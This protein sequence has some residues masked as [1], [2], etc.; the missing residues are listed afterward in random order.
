MS[1][2]KY[3]TPKLNVSFLVFPSDRGPLARLRA[4]RPRSQ[5]GPCNFQ[6]T[7]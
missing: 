3:T 4:G 7:T 5:I 6:L 2:P 1:L